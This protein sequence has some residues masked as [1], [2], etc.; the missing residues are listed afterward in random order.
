MSHWLAR[1]VMAAPL[2][3][4]SAPDSEFECPWDP[5]GLILEAL[6]PSIPLLPGHAPF[7]TFCIKLHVPHQTFLYAAAMRQTRFAQCFCDFS[8]YSPGLGIIATF[9]CSGDGVHKVSQPLA[10]NRPRQDLRSVNNAPGLR[11]LC[12]RLSIYFELLN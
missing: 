6:F 4:H 12:V 2:A 3:V 5:P 11:Y 9:V 1:W 10:S 8:S 7:T